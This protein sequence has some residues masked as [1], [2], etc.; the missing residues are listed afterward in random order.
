MVFFDSDRWYADGGD[1]KLRYNYSLNSDS[2]VVDLGGYKGDF[3][4]IIHTKFNSNVYVFE[5]FK[6]FYNVIEERF[7]SNEK[8][9]VFCKY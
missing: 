6:E 3:A 1:L 5:P 8:I 2:I 7:N 9:R 4:D